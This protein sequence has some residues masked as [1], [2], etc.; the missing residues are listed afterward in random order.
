MV[1]RGPA[2]ANEHEDGI[3]VL[4]AVSWGLENS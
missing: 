3:V 2:A 4:Q 1:I